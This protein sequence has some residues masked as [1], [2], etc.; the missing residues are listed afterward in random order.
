M[1][2]VPRAYVLVGDVIMVTRVEG[3]KYFKRHLD[4]QH[5]PVAHWKDLL[6]P[7]PKLLRSMDLHP[8]YRNRVR[9]GLIVE[10][11]PETHAISVLAARS[12]NTAAIAELREADYQLLILDTPILGLPDALIT[13]FVKHHQGDHVAQGNCFAELIHTESETLSLIPMREVLQ[14]ALTNMASK[15][16]QS[17]KIA[18]QF[19]PRN[20]AKPEEVWA[21]AALVS[22][23]AARALALTFTAHAESPDSAMELG[24]FIKKYYPDNA[25]GCGRIIGWS[26]NPQK[27]TAHRIAD[28]IDS[29]G[30]IISSQYGNDPRLMAQALVRALKMVGKI[31]SRG[32][33]FIVATKESDTLRNI[34]D[35][36]DTYYGDDIAQRERFA[37]M[38]EAYI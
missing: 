6:E 28:I 29:T 1:S 25:I 24:L 21:Q 36:A 20:T 34:Y 16:D 33:S 30:I 18:M 17:I 38:F 23:H 8:L 11:G 27:S 22:D 19:M 4:G 13:H 32:H 37:N 31:K 26:H 35:I 14:Q 5:R 10:A 15:W 7:G 12:G 9:N 3:V 2:G